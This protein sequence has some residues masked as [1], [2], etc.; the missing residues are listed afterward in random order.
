MSEPSG[1][2]APGGGAL[3]P[4]ESMPIAGAADAW[5]HRFDPP[6]PWWDA[7][8]RAREDVVLDFRL[9]T[10]RAYWTDLDDVAFW[11]ARRG[12]DPLALTERQVREYVAL[13]RRRRYSENT[14]RRRITSL[15]KFFERTNPPGV[16]PAEAVIIKRQ[17][18]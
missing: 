6:L 2:G 3:Y 17:R 16:N 9:N 1:E 18:R 10:A 5:A 13:L 14:I 12:L 8:A 7:F 11:C 15:R 4:D